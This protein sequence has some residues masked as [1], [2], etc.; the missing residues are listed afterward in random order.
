M[1]EED[2]DNRTFERNCDRRL[3]RL[4]QEDNLF[5]SRINLFLVAESMMLISYITSL[6]LGILNK[7]ISIMLSCLAILISCVF[8]LI[9]YNHSIHIRQLR[10]SLEDM[11]PEY[12]EE[13]DKKPIVYANVF[14]G[15]ILP[16]IFCIVWIAF[17][18]YSILI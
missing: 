2:A 12:K 14:L 16:L 8:L 1:D 17:L 4:H 9:L 6:N 13:R 10:V 3:S 5:T 7:W 11:Y 15:I 18:I